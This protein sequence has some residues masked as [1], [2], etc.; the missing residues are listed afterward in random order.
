MA[1]PRGHWKSGLTLYPPYDNGDTLTAPRRLSW[2]SVNSLNLHNSF[3]GLLRNIAE[4]ISGDSRLPTLVFEFET[5]RVHVINVE[6]QIIQTV[7]RYGLR[8][9][10]DL[11]PREVLGP[12]NGREQ[13]Y[14][15]KIHL[16][17]QISQSQ[18][19]LISAGV[20]H[21]VH[22]RLEDP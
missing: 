8:R 18:L 20:P 16:L 21:G 22:I 17:S 12:G 19:K 4:S 2:Q 5:A 6:D 14:R 13:P 15:I 9:V 10:E 7:D 3:K 1:I 11:P